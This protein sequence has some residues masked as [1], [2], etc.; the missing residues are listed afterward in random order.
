[1]WLRT[2][3]DL[4]FNITVA[5]P[6]ILMLRPRSGAQQWVGQ[7]EY[8]IVP[9]VPI[10]EYTDTYGNFC[11]RLIAP[12]GVFSIYTTAKVMI[13]DYM[14]QQPGAPFIEIRN[15]P[16]DVLGY[17]LPSRFC[18]ADHFSQMTMSIT[19]DKTLGYD[20]VV[21]IV[22]WIRTAIRFEPNGSDLQ[23]TAIDVNQRGWGVC[24]DLAHLGIAMCRSISIPARIVVGYLYGLEPMDLHAWFEVYVGGRWYLFDATQK[25]FNGGYV[26][27]GYG[28]DAADV[29]TYNQF[30]PALQLTSQYISVEKIDQPKGIPDAA[31]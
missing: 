16:N 23:V 6:F 29:A 26:A 28:R 24:R 9:N 7:E 8:K 31:L 12:P 18:P 13:A 10:F 22:Q 27:I 21:A 14:D 5:T 20:Q 19:A 4:I 15:L 11:Q 17:L 3:C 2:S 25:D 1:M 30:G